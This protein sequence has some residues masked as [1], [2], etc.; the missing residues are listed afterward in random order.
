MGLFKNTATAKTS[1]RGTFYHDGSFVVYIEKISVLKTRQKGEGPLIESRVIVVLDGAERA[2]MPLRPGLM[3]THMILNKNADMFDGN[4][5]GAIGQLIVCK[6]PNDNPELLDQEQW[7]ELLGEGKD[8]NGKERSNADSPI[9]NSQQILS[10]QFVFVEAKQIKTKEDRDFTIIT[11]RYGLVPSAVRELMKSKGVDEKALYP[12][13][14]LEK[15]IA[16]E[17][18]EAEKIAKAEAARVAAAPAA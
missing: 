18:A 9:F 4:V 14:E 8:E 17:R 2:K 3:A 6:D 15:M 7:E 1:Q 5:K 10:G 11:Y 12:G 13:G 16:A